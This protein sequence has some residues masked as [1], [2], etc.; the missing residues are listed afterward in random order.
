M[1]EYRAPSVQ[2]VAVDDDDSAAIVESLSKA[3]IVSPKAA[4]KA[5]VAKPKKAASKPAVQ[6]KRNVAKRSAQQA[7][8]PTAEEQPSDEAANDVSGAIPPPRATGKAKPSRKRLAMDS[9]VA[10]SGDSTENAAQAAG[11]DI[12]DEQPPAKRASVAASHPAAAAVASVEEQKAQSVP[13]PSE[14]ASPMEA[15]NV[16]ST[17][18][19]PAADAMPK[20]GSMKKKTKAKP[21]DNSSAQNAAPAASAAAIPAD[22]SFGSLLRARLPKH[23]LYMNASPAAASSKMQKVQADDDSKQPRHVSFAAGIKSPVRYVALT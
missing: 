20:K 1:N 6:P 4:K 16:V 22:N 2:D 10:A 7:L 15:E 5:K 9:S 11:E 13:A 8:S 18:N 17:A 3:E 12:P 19:P 21:A 23:A 14:T